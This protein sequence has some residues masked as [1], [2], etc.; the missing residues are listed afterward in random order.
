VILEVI[1]RLPAVNN[2][3]TYSYDWDLEQIEAYKHLITKNSIAA[4]KPSRAYIHLSN[5]F[6]GDEVLGKCAI[7][8]RLLTAIYRHLLCP[9]LSEWE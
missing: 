2:T 8:P 9:Q 1:I 4:I 6:D 7:L 5:L 3:V